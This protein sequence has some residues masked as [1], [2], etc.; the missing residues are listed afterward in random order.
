MRFRMNLTGR[1]AQ[2]LASS[3]SMQGLER[4]TRRPLVS[5]SHDPAA[6]T[7]F[8]QSASDP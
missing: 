5:N 1:G 2:L 6:R 8:T 3:V 7:F 4:L